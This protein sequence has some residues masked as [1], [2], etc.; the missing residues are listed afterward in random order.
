MAQTTVIDTSGFVGTGTFYTAGVGSSSF[1]QVV[2]DNGPQAGETTV[3]HLNAMFASL[4]QGGAVSKLYSHAGETSDTDCTT[5]NLI[6]VTSGCS[7]S[8][9]HILSESKICSSGFWRIMIFVPPSPNVSYVNTVTS[10]PAYNSACL[11]V[12]PYVSGVGQSQ[13]AVSRLVA[14]EFI[15][16]MGDGSTNGPNN[17]YRL[18]YTDAYSTTNTACRIKGWAYHAASAESVG[19]NLLDLQPLANARGS[20]VG[21]L[22]YRVPSTN[23]NPVFSTSWGSPITDARVYGYYG[24]ASPTRIW[25]TTDTTAS[26]GVITRVE[27]GNINFPSTYYTPSGSDLTTNHGH[28]GG[29]QIVQ[30]HG[31]GISQSPTRLYAVGSRSGGCS[32]DTYTTAGG[33]FYGSF[34]LGNWLHPGSSNCARVNGGAPVATTITQEFANRRLIVVS[35]DIDVVWKQCSEGNW[36]ATNPN[37]WNSNLNG[38]TTGQLSIMSIAAESTNPYLEPVLAEVIWPSYNNSVTTNREYIPSGAVSVTC[39]GSKNFA[40]LGTLPFCEI[41]YNDSTQFRILRSMKIVRLN[42]A[43]GEKWVIAEMAALASSGGVGTAM[44]GSM[45]SRVEAGTHYSVAVVRGNDHQLY[46]STRTNFGAWSTWTALPNINWTLIGG[47]TLMLTAPTV[48]GVTYA[49]SGFAKWYIV[50]GGRNPYPV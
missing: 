48:T 23:L 22:G 11:S 19:F 49:A 5:K 45:A 1:H 12:T 29:V 47:T 31:N 13:V 35:Q 46:V 30:E 39:V 41:M 21:G 44:P 9:C 43:E 26:T 24:P 2:L 17:E 50:F 14:R 34:T 36:C 7:K 15:R 32:L 20:W 8:G 37:G 18:A 38:R 25:T 27:S 16:L 10:A 4:F 3:H 33:Y 6:R 42:G 40:G 28:G